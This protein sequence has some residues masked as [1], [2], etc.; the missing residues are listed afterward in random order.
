[1]MDYTELVKELR[2]GCA[3]CKLWDG[4]RCCLDGDC[5]AQTR[6]QAADAIEEL[7]DLVNR[8]IGFW[9]SA[10]IAK[11]IHELNKY[12]PDITDP[13]WQKDHMEMGFYSPLGEV[14][15]DMGVYNEPP[16]EET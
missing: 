11:A 1:M 2:S 6:L 7:Q 5:T 3:T 14:Y 9:D 13:E 8:A 15:K 4:Y 12:M 10:E 16:K